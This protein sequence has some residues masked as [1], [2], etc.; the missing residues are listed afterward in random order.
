MNGFRIVV[1]GRVQ[2]VHFR[3]M[4]KTFADGK[5]L[6]GR[7][8]N[9]ADSSLEIVVNGSHEKVQ[10]LISWLRKSP[11]ISRVE[12]VVVEEI[13]FDERFGDFVIVRDNFLLWDQQRAMG[14]FV[15]Q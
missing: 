9:C 7:V 2:G 5:K 12:R 6:C 3:T 15:Q 8:R 14:N 13:A 1:S 4:V 10:T 11:G